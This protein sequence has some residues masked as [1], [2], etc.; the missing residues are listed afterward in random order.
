MTLSETTP[1]RRLNNSLTNHNL[2]LYVLAIL[3]KK[4]IHAYGFGAELR[5]RFGW[6]HG[7]IT[8]YVVLYK[9]EAEGFII[10]T[11]EE[12]RKYYTITPKGKQ[13]LAEAKEY[14][15]DLSGRL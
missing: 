13:I 3:S 2:W 1:M 8:T 14:L 15:T 10:A 4:R 5:D 7:L 9:L 6:N 12:R 11:Q